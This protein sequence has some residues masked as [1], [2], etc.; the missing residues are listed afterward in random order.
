[1]RFLRLFVGLV[2]SASLAVV[3]A[4]EAPA[5]AD[6][7]AGPGPQPQWQQSE[8]H[9]DWLVFCLVDA[10]GNRLGPCRMIQ[11]LDL[12]AEGQSVR[13]LEI[14]IQRAEEEHILQLA[15]PQGVDLRAGTAMQV[16]EG[17]Q[18]DIPY[19]V[20]AQGSCQVIASMGDD[21][22]EE[23]GVGTTLRIGFRFFGDDQTIALDASLSG[24]LAALRALERLAAEAPQ[25]AVN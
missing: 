12:E 6:P 20:C 25:S 8:V 17:E 24:S 9:G 5:A 7:L 14:S 3:Q 4:Q 1:M 22:I 15:F 10:A 18:T 2:F 13:L 23:L 11:T 16:D 19:S 21:L